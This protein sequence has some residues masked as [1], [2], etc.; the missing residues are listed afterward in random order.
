MKSYLNRFPFEDPDGDANY[1][2]II[3]VMIILLIFFIVLYVNQ[4][5]EATEARTAG[6]SQIADNAPVAAARKTE[7][8]EFS[9]AVQRHL[10]GMLGNGF[11]ISSAGP[12]FTLVLE[13]NLSFSSGESTLATD[14]LAILDRVAALI[15]EEKDYDVVISGHTDD[16]PIHKGPFRSNWHL[17]AARAVAVAEYLLARD[18]APQRLT[19]Q[20]LAEFHPLFANDTPQNRGKNRRVEITL[21]KKGG[22]VV[23]PSPMIAPQP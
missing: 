23:T 14:G 4:Q 10:E 17:S 3:D 5:E 8:P 15:L 12:S 22:T 13:E 2:G 1:W 9:Q 16:I 20:G 7:N 6:K 19:T 21:I 11:Y 18:V